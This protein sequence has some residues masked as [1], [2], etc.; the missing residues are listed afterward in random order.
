MSQRGH[1]RERDRVNWYREE[2]WFAM[3]APASLG[4]V[5]VFAM[6]EGERVRFEE[7]K[8]NKDGGP[9]KNFGPKDRA[10]LGAM[11]RL[12][13]ADAYLVYWPPRK[14]PQVIPESEWPE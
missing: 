14:P 13:G 3:R 2:G 9:Y 12:A 10:E 1:Q 11:A 8:S 7:L 4:E 6:K 5:D